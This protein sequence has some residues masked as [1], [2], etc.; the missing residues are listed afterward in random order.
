M[1]GV[2]SILACATGSLA[3]VLVVGCSSSPMHEAKPDGSGG[4]SNGSG[5][6]P[7]SGG[8]SASDAGGGAP[9][10]KFPS[11]ALS[12]FGTPDDALKIELRTSPAQVHVGPDNEGELRIS[13]SATGDPVDG[14]SIGVS[15][16][17]PVMGHKCAEV[18]VHVKAQGG[19][20]YL[21]TPLV[22]SMPGKCELKLS[23]SMPLPDGGK[24]KSVAV[25]SPTFDVIQSE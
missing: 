4:G 21:L 17:M 19:G 18:P 25:V 1:Q 23:I 2:K 20:A 11:E 10:E 12:T 15:T 16:W 7:G 3:L 5:G 24:G 22:A 13:D 8:V 6:I 9:A 14:L